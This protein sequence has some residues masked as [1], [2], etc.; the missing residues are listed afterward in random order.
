MKLART[1][2]VGFMAL[3][4]TACSSSGSSSS[5]GDFPA[6]AYATA[7]S[8][9][10]KYDLAVR[11]APAQPPTP[12]TSRAKLTIV[13]A[14]TQAPV[15][16]AGLSVVPWMPSMGH[17]ASVIPT[18]SEEGGGSYLVDNVTFFMQGQWQLR[19]TFNAPTEDHA[20]LDI[21]VP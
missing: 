16:G 18:V 4:L 1:C 17:G 13:D 7:T 11:F 2:T 14:R 10:G 8:D 9:S 19:V 21:T 12:G 20:N 6:D 5:S 3:M 15:E